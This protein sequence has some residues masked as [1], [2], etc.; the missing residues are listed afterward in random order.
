MCPL[1]GRL[2]P[3]TQEALRAERRAEPRDV[4]V[5]IGRWLTGR[6]LPTLPGCRGV[7][8]TWPVECPAAGAVR[9]GFRD[10]V[11]ALRRLCW[12]PVGDVD[13]LPVQRSSDQV[14]VGVPEFW[15]V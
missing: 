2:R 15:P 9:A 3:S 11:G 5:V 13:E 12:Y 4:F 10:E 14:P 1:C 8:V 6:P 7:A